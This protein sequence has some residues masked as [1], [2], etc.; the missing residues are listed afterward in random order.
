MDTIWQ[1]RVI[2]EDL[3]MRLVFTLRGIVLIVVS[4]AVSTSTLSCY[5]KLEER[6]RL[7]RCTL[8]NIA[9]WFI[10]EGLSDYYQGK[11]LKYL[12]E[13]IRGVDSGLAT[14]ISIEKNDYIAHI[15]PESWWL[16]S[17]TSCFAR[18]KN[19]YVYEYW[20]IQRYSGTR[21]DVD[22]E[23][24]FLITRAEELDQPR[25]II[26][27]TA[28]F[29]PKWTAPDG[30]VINFPMDNKSIYR[31]KPWYYPES[32]KGTELEGIEVV[33]ENKEYVRKKI[34]GS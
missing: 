4:L 3:T 33:I 20:V 11:G 29:F 24:Y 28:D 27:R 1:L 10:T 17:P 23:I 18:V 12:E 21:G 25:V 8:E 19:K 6:D 5:G 30:T 31:L 16:I 26:Y 15:V 34:K 14:E 2:C 22:E 13:R 7:A 32:F 9:V